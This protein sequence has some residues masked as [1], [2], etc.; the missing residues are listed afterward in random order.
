M[1]IADRDRSIGADDLKV[2]YQKNAAKRL[3]RA[4]SVSVAT[5]KLWLSGGIPD[6]RTVTI[7]AEL[8]AELARQ[9][10]DR[11]ALRRRIELMLGEDA[12]DQKDKSK[13][14]AATPPAFRDLLLSIARSA[15]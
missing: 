8:R 9:E 6:A 7:A 1:Q 3:A 2:V 12:T 11:A 15:A 4:L 13:I 5:A 10:P 14:R